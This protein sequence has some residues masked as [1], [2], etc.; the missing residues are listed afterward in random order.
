[1]YVLW[2]NQEKVKLVLLSSVL[3]V[4][5][6]AEEVLFVITEAHFGH[7]TVLVIVHCECPII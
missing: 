6:T 3:T 7:V 4:I 1:M 5:S 2:Y